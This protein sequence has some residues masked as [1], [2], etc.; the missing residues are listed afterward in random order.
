MLLFVDTCHSAG[1]T[2][3]RGESSRGLE[4]NLI[5]LYAEKL[6]YQEEG[7]AIITASDVNE[8]SQE[9]PRWGGGHGVF[10]H[11]LLE[12]MGGTADSN[13]DSVVTV[14]ELFRFVRQRVRLDTEYRQNPR[15]LV[16]TNEDLALSA[17]AAPGRR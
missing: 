14:G 6:L 9:S 3:S 1:L 4:N 2:G 10:T 11:F 15:M 5:S 17:V 13:V 16:G 12:G 8:S 7:K